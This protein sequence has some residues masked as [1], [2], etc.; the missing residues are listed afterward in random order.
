MTDSDLSEQELL[1][2]VEEAHR[3]AVKVRVAPRTTELLVER[4]EAG[5]TV[6]VALVTHPS[7]AAIRSFI[8]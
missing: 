1:E 7:P 4:G 3:R 6:E 5:R 8:S 2:T